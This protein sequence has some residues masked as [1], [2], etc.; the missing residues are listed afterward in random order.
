MAVWITYLCPHQGTLL[1][2]FRE[3]GSSHFLSARPYP[4]VTT[5][6]LS[7]HTFFVSTVSIVLDT[8]CLG[9]PCVLSLTDGGLAQGPSVQGLEQAQCHGHMLTQSPKDTFAHWTQLYQQENFASVA[10]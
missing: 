10:P 8:L 5:H 3:K 9:G 1:G 6:L 4:L 2:R 7:A